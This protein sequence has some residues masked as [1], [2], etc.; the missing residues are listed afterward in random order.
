MAVE[1]ENKLGFQ[2]FFDDGIQ[3]FNGCYGIIKSIITRA[4]SERYIRVREIWQ[5]NIFRG[6]EGL[7]RKKEISYGKIWEITKIF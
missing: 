6:R 3:G 7:S 5:K 4:G 2:W 1:G